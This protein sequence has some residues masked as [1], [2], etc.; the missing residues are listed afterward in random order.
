MTL[1]FN[2]L[3]N[4]DLSDQLFS[5][6]MNSINYIDIK[7]IKALY[8]SIIRVSGYRLGTSLG[9]FLDPFYKAC[10]KRR[11]YSLNLHW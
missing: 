9:V 6:S 10:M 2:I 3:T 8:I 7:Y 5:Y 1:R 4:N 11:K